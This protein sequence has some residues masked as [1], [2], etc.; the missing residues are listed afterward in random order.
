MKLRENSVCKDDAAFSR[1][2]LE[3]LGEQSLVDAVRD[4][5]GAHSTFCLRDVLISRLLLKSCWAMILQDVSF[6]DLRG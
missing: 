3:S 4:A 5:P 1:A 2:L 6:L